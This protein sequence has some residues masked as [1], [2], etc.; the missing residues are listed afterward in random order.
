MDYIEARRYSMTPI[1]TD[2]MV[3]NLSNTCHI[4]RMRKMKTK[5]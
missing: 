4:H 2:Y 1:S 5:V 3:L